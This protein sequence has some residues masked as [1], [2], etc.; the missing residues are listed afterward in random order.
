MQELLED[1]RIIYIKGNHE[2]MMLNAWEDPFDLPLWKANG[3]NKTRKG[4][5][6][7]PHSKRVELVSKLK[8]K[9]KDFH[10]YYSNGKTIFLTHSGFNPEIDK[11][12]LD[13]RWNRKHI[14]ETW[15]D[16]PDFDNLVLIH[17]HTIT[18]TLDKYDSKVNPEKAVAAIT[19]CQGHKIDID[20]GTVVTGKACL[21]DLDT[22]Q[23][24]YFTI[25]K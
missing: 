20:M 4:L 5:M 19:Y 6:C 13:T 11:E 18:W 9:T 17:G 25:E 10:V 7:L 8:Y 16:N 3:A 15:P 1:P 21:L 24:I 14:A 2:E 22:L 23:P 12:P